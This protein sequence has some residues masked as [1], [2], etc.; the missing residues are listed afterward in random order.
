MKNLRILSFRDDISSHYFRNT[1]R[2]HHKVYCNISSLHC[3]F[4]SLWRYNP[5]LG[6]GLPPWNSPFHFCLL[7]L[8]HSLGLLRR[9]IS[10]LQGLYLYTNTEKHIHIYKHQTSIP[11]RGFEPTIPTSERPKTVHALDR[12]AIVTDLIT[13]TS[14]KKI[15]CWR[16]YLSKNLY[17]LVHLEMRSRLAE[18]HSHFPTL[19]HGVGL[20]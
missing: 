11:L 2:E 15:R 10:S 18:L 7:G 20:N 19:Q 9:V 1:K 4:F 13:C 8:K 12:L 6:L 16:K 17:F 3:V 14:T 5:N